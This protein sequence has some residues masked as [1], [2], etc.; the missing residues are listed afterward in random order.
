MIMS[1]QI[2]C[3]DHTDKMSDDKEDRGEVLTKMLTA[4]LMILAVTTDQS[5]SMLQL[6]LL[7]KKHAFVMM[8]GLLECLAC[9]N[10]SCEI[11]T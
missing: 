6:I 11:T 5:A 3:D 1:I 2:L 9:G 7:K 8:A 10:I 4:R